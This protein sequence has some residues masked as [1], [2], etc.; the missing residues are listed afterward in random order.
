M[1][2]K[3]ISRRT[4]IKGAGTVGLAVST[5]GFPAILRSATKMEEVEIGFI[6]PLSGHTAVMGNWALKGWNLA[7]DEINKAGG[8]KSLGGAKIKTVLGDTQSVPRVGMAEVEKVARNKNVP[9][10][11]GCYQSAVTFPATQIAEQYG[12]PFIVDISTQPAICRR[13]FKYVFRPAP[14]SDLLNERA[15]DFIE[16]MG[17]Q[18]G[19][20]AKRV[21]ILG[22]D[23][24]YGRSS[25]EDFKNAIKKK[26]EQEIV[27]EIYYPVK[28]TSVDVEIA[29]IKAA[30]VDVI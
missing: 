16:D 29:K 28:V 21:A 9:V 25:S 4:F 6:Y 26:T 17:K 27:E 10:V 15:V 14:P 12:L 24:N 18:T 8:I 11:V 20:R 22:I 5:I 19:F 23:D 3:R 13:G 7:V 30:N 2:K 1:K